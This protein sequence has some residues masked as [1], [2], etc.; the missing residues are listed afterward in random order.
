MS[1]LRAAA[2]IRRIATRLSQSRGL[3]RASLLRTYASA[4][5]AAKTPESSGEQPFFPNEPA[6]PVVKTAIPG[7]KSKQ[8]IE[9]LDKVFDTRAIN[10]LANY[11][12]SCGNYIS[13]PDGNVLL[14][15]Y[16]F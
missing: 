4:T 5:A 12:Q 6:G 3:I 10:M 9:E 1:S 16:V 11:E 15:V 7:P 13:D 14:D 8:A 2:R